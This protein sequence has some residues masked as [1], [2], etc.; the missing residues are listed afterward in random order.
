MET[1]I[2]S[3]NHIKYLGFLKIYLKIICL[4]I[5]LNQSLA[6]YRI[7]SLHCSMEDFFEF[8]VLMKVLLSFH[9]QRIC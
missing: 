5:W 6:A 9:I 7:F 4:F 8:H 3:S 2:G 1:D